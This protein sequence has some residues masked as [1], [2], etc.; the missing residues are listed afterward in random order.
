MY[1]STFNTSL[2]GLQ[3]S[4]ERFALSLTADRDDARDLL[5]ETFLKALSY[6]DKFQEETNLKAWTFTIMRNT[7]INRY[8]KNLKRKVMNGQDDQ[9]LNVFNFL[10]QVDPDTPERVLVY[11]EIKRFVDNLDDEFRIPF[12]MHT[13]GYKYREI[14]DALELKIG[15]VKSRIF[16][17]RKKLMISLKDYDRLK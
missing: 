16:F 17:A 12:K 10:K 14:A 3:G 15:T 1:N 13:S 8:R 11:D 7:F 6:S 9:M 2:I 4:L 5:Q